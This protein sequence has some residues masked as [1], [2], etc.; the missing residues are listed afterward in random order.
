MYAPVPSQEPVNSVVVVCLC[1]AYLFFVHFFIQ[2]RPCVFSFELFYIAILDLLKLTMRYRLCS[3]LKAVVTYNLISV[4][5]W[6]LAESGL[7]LAIIA[8]LL[9]SPRLNSEKLQ[10]E[11][12]GI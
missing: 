4:S 12:V 10:Q 2:I 11:R 9:S 3:L 7:S 1:V 8:H 5:F 6:S